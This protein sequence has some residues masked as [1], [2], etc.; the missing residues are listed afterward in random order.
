MTLEQFNSLDKDIAAAELRKC[1]GADNWIR[2]MMDYFPFRSKGELS[3][4]AG[5]IWNQHCSEND[6]LEAFKHHPKIGDIESLKKK[7]AATKDWAGNEQAGVKRADLTTIQ[8]LLESNEAYEHK[9]GFIFIVCATGKSAE[10]MLELLKQRINN[11]YEDEIKIAAA[12]QNKITEIRIN[13]LLS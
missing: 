7:F 11:T 1:C 8:Q 5:K 4:L 9:F 10:E 2:L 6:W 13:K 3:V 12:E